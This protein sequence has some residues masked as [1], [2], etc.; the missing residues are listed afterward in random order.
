MGNV[1]VSD[2]ST[3]T[4]TTT[5]DYERGLLAVGWDDDFMFIYHVEFVY[6]RNGFE[7]RVCMC[8]YMWNEQKTNI[9]TTGGET[10]FYA[11]SHLSL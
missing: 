4:T 9:T 7:A 8:V 3:T 2:A 1:D 11:A 5:K 6:H 10:R